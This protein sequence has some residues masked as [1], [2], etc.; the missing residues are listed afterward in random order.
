M[1]PRQVR[2][3]TAKRHHRSQR[4]WGPNRDLPW[5]PVGF[6]V[7]K[8]TIYM[9]RS[10]ANS[11]KKNRF[12]MVEQPEICDVVWTPQPAIYTETSEP[13]NHDISDIST[14]FFFRK[15][16]MENHGNHMNPWRSSRRCPLGS[17]TL[18]NHSV[19]TNLAASCS[20]RS[21]LVSQTHGFPMAICL[22]GNLMNFFDSY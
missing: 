3:V 15:V 8:K 21:Q 19:F 11:P 12:Y 2:Q 5:W 16:E 17:W 20:R 22:E 6:T 9:Q 4:L 14:G 10:S 1:D 13:R 18:K 7:E